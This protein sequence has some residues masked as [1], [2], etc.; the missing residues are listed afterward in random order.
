MS[1]ECLV[2]DIVV[3]YP[4]VM[5]WKV[6]GDPE[7]YPRFFRGVAWCERVGTTEHGNNVRH[8]VRVAPGDG[9]LLEY[10]LETLINRP[11]EQL[12]FCSVP[13]TGGWVSVRLLD[14]SP[15]RTRVKVVFFKP[16][17][18]HPKWSLWSDA[19]IKAWAATGLMRISDYL[20]RVPGPVATNGKDSMASQWQVA[21]ILIGA[22]V[23]A[24]ARPDRANR[25]LKALA[26]WGGTLAGG[27]TAAAARSPDATAIVDEV[28]TLTFA[29]VADR[30]T[31]LAN[32]LRRMGAGPGSRIGVLARNHGAMVE[33]LVAASKLGVD[34]VLLNTGLSAQ[35]F[36][37]ITQRHTIT[38]LIADD[39][40]R[41]LVRY[42]P[43]G[44]RQLSIRP[45][46]GWPTI[47]DV[48]GLPSPRPFLSRIPVAGRR[49]HARGRPAVPQLGFRRVADRHAAA[50]DVGA[51]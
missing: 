16:S 22:G 42:L 3:E 34:A 17:L 45:E 2:L 35:Q 33:T 50:R 43:P 32:G 51:A 25:Q 48:L 13:D 24:P 41:Q 19:A 1:A 47:E 21:R 9:D 12:V 14:E 10:Q 30:T 23:L 8:R 38:L 40:F 44:V 11:A 29:E 4:R 7:Q 28:G 18:P 37:D 46:T 26:R 36:Y 15:G 49:T 31:R 6:L 27:Y 20:V 39:E 5:L